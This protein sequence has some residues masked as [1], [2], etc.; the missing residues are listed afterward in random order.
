ME[1]IPIGTVEGM[2]V[3]HASAGAI[4]HD[5][6]Q[7]K[8]G[9]ADLEAQGVGH[10]RTREGRPDRLTR[11]FDHDSRPLE[12]TEER[13]RREVRL[14]VGQA[15]PL[16]DVGGEIGERSAVDEAN[17]DG[18]LRPLAGGK[19]ERFRDGFRRRHIREG[20]Q[21]HAGLAPHLD[22][23]GENVRKVGHDGPNRGGF[24]N[25]RSGAGPPVDQARGGQ[26]VERLSNRRPRDAVFLGER[27][28]A[29][30]ARA[31]RELTAHDAFAQKKIQPTRLEG[32]DACVQG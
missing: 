3:L 6:R 18:A 21:A 13:R 22:K 27:R 29:G 15:D 26:R 25:E 31:G 12:E 4:D 30:Q 8:Q 11:L 1:G 10:I 14:R 5:P 32:L 2:E 20:Q 7:R 23:V 16:R 9:R 19:P 24:A 17:A 28:F